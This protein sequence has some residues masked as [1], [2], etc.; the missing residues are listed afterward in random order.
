M[1]INPYL[2]HTGNNEE[3]SLIADLIEESIQFYGYDVQYCV[4][5][6]LNYD[7]VI[8]EST[9]VA[10]NLAFPIEMYIKSVDQYGGDGQF[11]SNIG[12][13][14]RHQL[15]LSVSLRRWGLVATNVD[16]AEDLVRPREGDVIYFALDN[17][18]LEIKKVDR[19]S[20]FY[21]VGSLYT[22]DLTCEVLEYTGEDF[23]TGVAEI[24]AIATSLSINT[25]DHGSV[26]NTGTPSFDSGYEFVSK[27]ANNTVITTQGEA[28]IDFSEDNRLSDSF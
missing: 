20:V 3:Q 10:F 7:E 24:D 18:L 9:N 26:S 14:I 11:L 28:L 4:R 8:G 12:I 1:A 5:S 27:F 19:Y 13:Q 23:S 6:N 21:Q 25:R 15:M 17:K 22:Y 2:S 16:T